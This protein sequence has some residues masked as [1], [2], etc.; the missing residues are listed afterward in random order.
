MRTRFYLLSLLI[1]PLLSACQQ[2][3]PGPEQVTEAK[4]ESATI[5]GTVAYR[6]RIAL[7]PQATL[8]V[9]LEDVSRADARSVVLAEKELADIGQV[10]IAFELDY[11]PAA[12]DERMTYVIRAQ[13]HDRGGLMFTTDTHTPV[14]TRGAGTH[15]DITLVR[16]N[17][18]TVSPPVAPPATLGMDLEGMFRYMADAAVF[19]DCRNDKTYPVSMEGAYIDVERAYLASGVEAGSEAMVRLTGRLLERPAMEGDRKVVKLVID[20]FGEIVPGD[21]C[22]PETHADLLNTYWKLLEVDGRPVTAP[23]G[24]KEAHVILTT[25]EARAHGNAGCNNFFGQYQV[26]NDSL[27]F[28]GMGSTMMACPDGMDT[29]QAFLAALGNTNRYTISGLFL[30]LYQDDKLLARLEAIYL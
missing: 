21:E 23:E 1:L 8:K 3:P 4:P 14:L 24:R 5:S 25:E 30:E 6:E 29:E 2:E 26:E 12:I 27:S 22:A 28:S 15:V 18:P 20:S 13:I 19:R 17:R 11:D 9:S 10:P 16:V 7:S